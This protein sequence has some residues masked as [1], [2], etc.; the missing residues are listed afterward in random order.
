VA[1]WTVF[2]DLD[3]QVRAT[4]LFFAIDTAWTVVR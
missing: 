3:E 1:R 2:A 4:D